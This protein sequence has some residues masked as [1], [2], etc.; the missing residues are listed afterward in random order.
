ML[1]AITSLPLIHASLFILGILSLGIILSVQ[2]K[3]H[4]YFSLPEREPFTPDQANKRLSFQLI[5]CARSLTANRPDF[6]R[7][8]IEAEM[9]R[10]IDPFRKRVFLLYRI[11]LFSF[12]TGSSGTVFD[13][14]YSY[15]RD[16]ISPLSLA[17]SL[18]AS[19]SG[20]FIASASFFFY[21]KLNGK[22][23][24]MIRDQEKFILLTIGSFA[25]EK[26]SP[27]PQ[28]CHPSLLREHSRN[29]T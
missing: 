24:L 21:T 15:F 13:I 27:D 4:G 16:V 12:L 19:L 5:L 28:K 29:R 17:H 26:H 8:G 10:Q 3:L 2:K 14:A 20:L 22:I 9:K 6:L 11:S 18:L 23:D 1:A 7:Q 25:K